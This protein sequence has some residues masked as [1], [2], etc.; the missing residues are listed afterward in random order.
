MD[1]IFLEGLGWEERLGCGS[2]KGGGGGSFF[3]KN[4][5][6]HPLKKEGEKKGASQ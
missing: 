5:D 2:L 1:H 3:E 6:F 4:P